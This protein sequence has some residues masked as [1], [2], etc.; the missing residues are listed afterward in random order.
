M[1]GNVTEVS[2]VMKKIKVFIKNFMNLYTGD[3]LAVCAAALSFQMTLTFFPL[4]ICLYTLLGNSYEN[5]MRIIEMADG[6]L[7]DDTIKL[8]TDF[9]GYVASNNSQAMMMGGIMLLITMASAAVRTLSGTIGNM[10]GGN[11]FRG[12]WDY[13]ISLLLSVVLLAAIYFAV[14][15]MFTGKN[16]I[17][18]VNRYIPFFD[19]SSSWRYLRYILLGG[20]FFFLICGLFESCKRKTDM[21]GTVV[22]SLIT[23]AALVAASYFFAIF[24]SKSARYSLVYG[25]L[26]SLILLMLWLY[27][28]CLIICCGAAI[29]IAIRDTRKELVEFAIDEER[30]KQRN[31]KSGFMT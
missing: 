26:A 28:C 7:A 25:S 24:I 31:R 22:G 13:L 17:D 2:G 23:T 6:V 27:Y 5:L 21:Y 16:F 4:L 29:N 12:L 11:R 18:L 1:R 8:I 14:I 10:Q 30:K 3:R 19:I 15:V 20:I 9:V